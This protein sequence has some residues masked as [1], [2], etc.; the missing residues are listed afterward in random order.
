MLITVRREWRRFECVFD[1]HNGMR[2]TGEQPMNKPALNP[3]RQV[4]YQFTDAGGIQGLVG[5]VRDNW[6]LL[7][8]HCHASM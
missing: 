8:L 5:L 3:P 4:W 6:R 1:L 2:S 7:Q